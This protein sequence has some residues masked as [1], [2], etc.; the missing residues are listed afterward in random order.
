MDAKDD[1]ERFALLQRY[2]RG[3][4]QPMWEVGERYGRV[5]EALSRGNHELALY[6]WNKIK[7]TIENGYLKRPKRQENADALFLNAA[8]SD[9]RDAF[10]SKDPVA[11][12]TGFE[13]AR[14]ACQACHVA[15]EVPFMNGQP[16]FDLRAP[17]TGAA[18]S[19]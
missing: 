3:F 19:G 17:G 15:E 18:A 16:L 8:W 7:T 1:A 6:H 4:D 5:H 12:W 13:Q 11:A 14:A 2:L 9:A 10:A